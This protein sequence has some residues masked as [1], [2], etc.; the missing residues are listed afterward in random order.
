MLVLLWCPTHSV[1]SSTH[2][3]KPSQRLAGEA[4]CGIESYMLIME[5]HRANVKM[6]HYFLQHCSS[7]FVAEPHNC[8]QLKLSIMWQ[9]IHEPRMLCA[10]PSHI[11]IQCVRTPQNLLPWKI[12]SVRKW[13][14]CLLLQ[15]LFNYTTQIYSVLQKSPEKK[16][17]IYFMFSDLFRNI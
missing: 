5:Q 16:R 4:S 9:K 17:S 13:G 14:L 3:L 8:K 10:F 6:P 11:K 15:L 1:N 12:P 7:M 2:Y